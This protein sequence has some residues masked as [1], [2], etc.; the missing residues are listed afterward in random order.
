MRC[1]LA[2][3]DPELA[4]RLLNGVEPRTPLHE[5]SLCSCRA[6]LAEAA[7]HH[8]EAATEYA[9]AAERWRV[10]GNVPERAYALLGQGRCLTE[11]ANP[12]A[13]KSLRQ[14][15]AIFTDIGAQSRVA[16]CHTLIARTAKH[17]S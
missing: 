14:A 12:T 8:S 2:L 13:E 1:T 7:G 6:Q 16:E 10:F 5:H 17:T 4:A 15:R 3:E 11:L 9:E